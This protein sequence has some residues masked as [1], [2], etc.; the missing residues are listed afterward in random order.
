MQSQTLFRQQAVVS[1]QQ[2]IDGTILLKP[3]LPTLGITLCLVCWLIAVVGWLISGRYTYTQTVSGWLEPAQGITHVYSPSAGAIVSELLVADNEVVS[4][5]TPLLRLSRDAMFNDNQS[6]N[7]ALIT[8]LSN[9]IE[10]L[11]HQYN[12]TEQGFV[13]QQQRLH[14]NALRL[15]AERERLAEMR[16]LL[17]DKM[18]LLDKQI[19][20]LSRLAEQGFYSQHQ[21]QT[22][23]TQKIDETYQR[24]HL[25]REWIALLQT[26]E[27]NQLEQDAAEN[28]HHLALL[29]LENQISELQKSLDQQ[30]SQQ[31]LLITAPTDGRVTNLLTHSG[32]FTQPN[33]PL[34]S[35]M[36]QNESVTAKLLVPVAAAGQIAPGQRIAIRYDAFPYTQFGTYD[37]EIISMSE[38]LLLPQEVAQTPISINMP[39]YLARA[40][41]STMQIEHLN[42]QISLRA[43]MTFVA[44][45]AIRERNL[46]EWLFE[47]LFEL[48]GGLL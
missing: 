18:T 4:K 47:P 32:Q 3:K 22:L 5:G 8:E 31:E 30:H 39:V 16:T 35:L 17:N 14:K 41:L 15:T 20:T 9:Q 45:I 24:Q 44:E 42:Q 48:K 43:G 1:Q 10:R 27:D 37:A 29:N 2:R 12:L 26:I 36:P 7:R 25:E 13:T 33:V 19:Q 11:Q 21:L 28:N 23:E 40:T 6:I 34:L 46:L 38:H